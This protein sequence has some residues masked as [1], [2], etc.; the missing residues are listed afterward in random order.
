MGRF[1]TSTVFVY[2]VPKGSVRYTFA[3]SPPSAGDK[4]RLEWR[5]P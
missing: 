1:G 4:T 3:F 5:V 2:R